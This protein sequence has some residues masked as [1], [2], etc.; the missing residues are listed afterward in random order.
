[1]ESGRF[2]KHLNSRNIPS[3]FGIC[4]QVKTGWLRAKFV[5]NSNAREADKFMDTAAI[6]EALKAD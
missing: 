2:Q 6:I 5:H 1:M 3:H 4:Q